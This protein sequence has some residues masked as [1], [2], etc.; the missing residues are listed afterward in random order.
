MP[1]VMVTLR[2]SGQG[3]PSAAGSSA[4]RSL[5]WA[6]STLGLLPHVWVRRGWSRNWYRPAHDLEQNRLV[7]VR[8]VNAAPHHWQSVIGPHRPLEFGQ[9]QDVDVVG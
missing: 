5:R 3:W 7:Y 1:A 6:L 9:A 8:G 4:A 2:H